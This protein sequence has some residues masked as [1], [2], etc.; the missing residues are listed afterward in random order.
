M[1]RLKAQGVPVVAVFLSGRPLWVNPYLNAADAFVA[2]WLP[3]SE[4]AGVADVLFGR[5]EFRG[6]LPYSWPK[7]ADQTPLNV[8]DTGYDPLFAYGFGLTTRDDGRLAPLSEARDGAGGDRNTLFARGKATG[9][10]RL[11]LGPAGQPLVANPG[12][13]LIGQR[14][15]DRAAQEDSV[16]LTWTGRAAATA[17]FVGAPVDLS[18]EANGDVALVAELRVDAAPTAPVTLNGVDVTARLRALAGRWGQVAVPLRCLAD[19]ARV[20]RPFAMTTA[21]SLDLTVSAVRF[22]SPAEGLVDCR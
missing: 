21:G 13:E 17:A 1:K 18:R 3:G 19:R 15:A 6:K 8:G 2:A 4:G 16:R 12:P 11:L 22:A 5:R 10:R 9:G 7:R 20:A 14:P